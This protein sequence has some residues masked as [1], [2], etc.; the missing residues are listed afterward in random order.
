MCI[1][2]ACIY[3]SIIPTL[4]ELYETLIAAAKSD[5]QKETLRTAFDKAMEEYN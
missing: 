3:E 2:E 4:D 1:N 5:Y